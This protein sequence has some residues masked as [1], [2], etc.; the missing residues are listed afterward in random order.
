MDT[1]AGVGTYDLQSKLPRLPVPGLEQTLSKLRASCAPF[2][3]EDSTL[4]ALLGQYA[5]GAGLAAQQHLELVVDKREPRNYT[6]QL[7]DN[8]A[9]LAYKAPL[10]LNTAAWVVIKAPH[11]ST[12]QAERA[13]RLSLGLLRFYDEGVNGRV[14]G[15]RLLTLFR[16]GGS[17]F[18]TR[19]VSGQA[20]VHDAVCTHLSQPAHS[21]SW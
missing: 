1:A 12:S 16:S 10:P 13:S 7:W 18:G 21:S 19:R 3:G 9:Y 2:V 15:C 4:D 5:T 14:R 17:A 20:V 8:A 6:E 11:R